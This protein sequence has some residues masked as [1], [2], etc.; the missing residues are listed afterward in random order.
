MSK[1]IVVSIKPEFANR[2]FDGTKKMELRKCSPNVNPEDLLIVYSTSPEMAIIGVCKIKKVI[3]STPSEIWENHS[4]ILG[5]DR[6]RFFQ[7]YSGSDVA[8]GII[9]ERVKRFKTKI[10]LKNLKKQFPTFS[11]P[12]T[13]KYYNRKP[14]TTS[15]DR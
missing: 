11:P 13:F 9:L 2:I 15:F 8:V 4:D 12:Q 5:I 14:I 1:L 10:P 6:E 3:K 7:Y